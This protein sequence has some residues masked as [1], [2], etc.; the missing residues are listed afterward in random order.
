MQAEHRFFE[1]EIDSCVVFHNSCANII[2]PIGFSK[3]LFALDDKYYA[4]SIH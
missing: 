3:M 4:V 2:R 1:K